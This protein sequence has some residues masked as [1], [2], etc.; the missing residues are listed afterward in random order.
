MAEYERFR[1]GKVAQVIVVEVAEGNGRD[2]PIRLVTYYLGLDGTVLAR[3][4]SL[5]P[6]VRPG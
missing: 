2:E 6:E 3:V 1:S 4:D 5:P